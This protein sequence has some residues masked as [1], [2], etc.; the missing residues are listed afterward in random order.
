MSALHIKQRAIC[1]SFGLATQDLYLTL[2]NHT[3]WKYVCFTILYFFYE[4]KKLE[5]INNYELDLK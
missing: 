3:S 2:V 4:L 1:L 5:R